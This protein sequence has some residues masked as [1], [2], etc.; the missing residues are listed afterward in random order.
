MADDNTVLIVGA[1]ITGLS[2]A[3]KLVA[4]GKRVL[5]IEKQAA[6]GGL[7]RSYRYGGHVFDI[8][9]HRFHSDDQRVISY[10][11]EICGDEL[12]TIPRS[13]GVHFVG[14]YF[15]WPLNP[16][17]ILRLPP[18]MLVRVGLDV[19]TLLKKRKA[20]R[21]F[22]DHIVN[23][24]GKTLYTHFFHDYS[25]KFLKISPEETHSDWA[26]TGVDRA[27][28]DE[29]LK[30][31]SLWQLIMSLTRPQPKTEFL[32]PRKGI[33]RFA[34]RLVERI[35]AGGGRVVCGTTVA[36][37][38]TDGD[39]VRGVKLSD[40]ARI[41]PEHLVWTA[42]L[43][44]LCSLVGAPETG[45]RYLA[46]MV[47]NIVVQGPARVPYQWCYFGDFDVIFNRISLPTRFSR[48]TFPPGCH[49]LCVEVTCMQGDP[50]WSD[51]EAHQQKLIADLLRVGMVGQ[52]SDILEIHI[53]PVPD[54]YP[55]YDIEY[56]EKREAALG[57]IARFENLTPAGRTGLF[58]YNNMDHSLANA[59]DLAQHGLSMAAD[60]RSFLSPGLGS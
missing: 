56:R 11:K 17:T 32:Y 34:E 48:E 9:P 50:V 24:F 5:V 18:W 29:R 12:I 54:S 26:K 40:G 7:A 49:G 60:A 42:P 14:K 27:I 57:A 2:L 55:I 6:P 28:I 20:V 52:R 53:E 13:S 38:E 16:M 3:Q 15:N 23:M 59:L 43:P 4:E 8:G 41:E 1:G 47:Y 51:P 45:L 19:F 58:W 22:R 30:M 46:L 39:R 44:E 36:G 21:S 37:V 33:G 31:R 25:T 35:E 10:V